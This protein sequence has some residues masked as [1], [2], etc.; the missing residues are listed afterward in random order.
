ME[1]WTWKDRIFLAIV[2]RFYTLVLAL[3]S[4]T[5]PKTELYAV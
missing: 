4:F 3:L 2:P 5:I 1:S